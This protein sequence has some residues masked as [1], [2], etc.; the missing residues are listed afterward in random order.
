MSTRG[1]TH[2]LCPPPSKQAIPTITSSLCPPGVVAPVPVPAPTN[3]PYPGPGSSGEHPG[4]HPPAEGSNG[5][6]V[7]PAVA[8]APP[9][10]GV[11]AGTAAGHTPVAPTESPSVPI[12]GADRRAVGGIAALALAALGLVM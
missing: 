8:P 11:P 3:P 9:A 12:S 6:G 4:G 2:G 10:E 7:P 5:E 1:L